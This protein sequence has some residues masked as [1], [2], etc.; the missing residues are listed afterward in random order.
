MRPGPVLPTAMIAL[1]SRTSTSA[2]TSTWRRETPLRGA[3]HTKGY[4]AF[5]CCSSARVCT[6]VSLNPSFNS[7]PACLVW[8][9]TLGVAPSAPFIV[10]VQAGLVNV[11][12]SAPTS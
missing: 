11:H 2:A 8:R 7:N 3:L 6:Q 4:A 12:R 9:P 1:S 5:R 10:P